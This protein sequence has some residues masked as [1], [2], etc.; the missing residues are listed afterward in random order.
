MIYQDD[1]I[2][3]PPG[4]VAAV[5]T[6][7]EMMSRVPARSGPVHGRLMVRQVEQPQAEW[8][9]ELYSRVGGTWLWY[10][11][12]AMTQPALEAIIGDRNVEVHSLVINGR[13]EGFA[14][15]DFRVAGECKLTYFGI[16]S[17]HIGSGAGRLLMNETIARAWARPIHRFWVHTCTLDHPGALAFYQRS[18]FVP[19]RQQLEVADDPRL[20]GLLPEKFA[21]QIPIYLR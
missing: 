1:Y 20:N 17:V 15:L 9:R 4:K 14:E 16:A 3:V 6:H 8:Y 10:E 11:R 19:F 21:P 18:G 7:L 12:L 13:D 2:D 5:V